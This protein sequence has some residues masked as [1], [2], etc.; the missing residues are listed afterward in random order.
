MKRLV[1][2]LAIGGLLAATAAVAAEPAGATTGDWTKITGP[3]GPGQPIYQLYNQLGS[4]PAVNISGTVSP[5][6]LATYG[7]SG[8]NVGLDVFCFQ[9]NDTA[10]SSGSNPLNVGGTAI[11]I[12]ADG[13]FSGSINPPNS[14]QCVLRA[15]P[16]ATVTFDATGH[17]SNYVA[18][19]AG[20]TFYVGAFEKLSNTAPK[21]VAGDIIAVLKRSTNF[22]G[23]ADL[24]GVGITVPADDAVRVIGPI[25]NQGTLAFTAANVVSSGSPTRSEIIVDGHHAYLPLTLDGFVTDHTTV[26]ASAVTLT[27]NTT[28]GEITFSESSPLRWCAGNAYPQGSG[29]CSPLPTGVTFKRTI[30]SSAGGAVT[31][32]RDKFVSTDSAAHSLKV[33]YQNIWVDPGNGNVG[34]KFP[35]TS[36]F[37]TPSA[38]TTVNNLPIGAHTILI[39]SDV[40][41]TD[42]SPDRSDYGLTYSG[43][44]QLFFGSQNVFG[45]RYTRTVPKN[46]AAAFGFAEEDGFTLS[47][48]I[49]LANAAQKAATPHMALTA[50]TLTTSDNTPTI[51]GKVTNATNGL[52]AKVTI[53]IGT[54]SKTVNVNQSTGTFAVTWT[55]LANGKHTA[56]AKAT[57]PSGFKLAASRT[58]KVT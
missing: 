37:K 42:G 51:K 28:T 55:F 21:V 4:P 38:G 58:F 26:P 15:V 3:K 19:F 39:T 33:E 43:K 20:P 31:T 6:V 56:T 16:H 47:S 44:P 30:A 46:G 18:S 17:T 40:H 13:S 2:I 34:Y 9:L 41:A 7:P 22:Y 14:T 8:T 24:F 50:P 12:L 11:A 36:S 1:R 23:S 48:V 25:T 54:K 10:T 53:T 57:D 45:M 27:R 52:P 49:T 5:T 29:T 32:V 35:G